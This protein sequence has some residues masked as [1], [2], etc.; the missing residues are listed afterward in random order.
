MAGITKGT[1]RS[2]LIILILFHS[3]RPR[4]HA[5]GIPIRRVTTT[6]KVACNS[7]NFKASFVPIIWK[8]FE[9]AEKLFISV[10]DSNL[11]IAYNIGTNRARKNELTT[12]H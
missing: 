11:N 9:I 1:E 8:K 10:T 2:A 6:E 4:Y 12:I 5:N 7:V 3:Y